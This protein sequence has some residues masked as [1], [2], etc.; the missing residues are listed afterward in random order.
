MMSL[1]L[2]MLIT[3]QALLHIMVT[4]NIL[5]ETGQPLPMISRGG[6]SLLFTSVALGLILSVSRQNIE[7]SYHKEEE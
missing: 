4:V 5:P 7:G 1:G 3:G 6:S 2:A